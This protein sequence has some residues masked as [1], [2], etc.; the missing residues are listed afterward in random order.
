MQKQL[1]PKTIKALALDLDGTALLPDTTMGERTAQCLRNLISRDIQVIF[2]TGRAIEGAERFRI[3]IGAEG[4]M[5]F[6]NGAEVADMPSGEIIS[7]DLLDLDVVNFG[8]DLA[9]SMG[10]HYQIYLPAGTVV[11]GVKSKWEALVV[12]KPTPESEMYRN[13][14]GI[15]P[16]VKDL[17]EVCATPGL[18]GCVKVMFITDPVRHEEIRQKT[19]DRFGSK[20]YVARTFP[21]FLEIMNAGVSKGEGLKTAMKRR[22]LEAGEVIALGDEENDLLMFNAAGFSAAPANAREKVRAAADFVFASNAGEGLAVFL[23][24]LFKI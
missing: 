12:D 15:V 22:G 14:T 18:R 19:L 24:D 5:V 13:H 11:D 23:E 9:R 4:P 7:A 8:I 16:Q 1:N 6:F 17:K 21:T 3:A 2:C 20:V 10:V